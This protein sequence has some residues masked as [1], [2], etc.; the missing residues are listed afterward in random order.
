MTRAFRLLFESEGLVVNQETLLCRFPQKHGRVMTPLITGHSVAAIMA[1]MKLFSFEKNLAAE[2][3][4][5]M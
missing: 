1:L 5:N 4:L 3:E 2:L